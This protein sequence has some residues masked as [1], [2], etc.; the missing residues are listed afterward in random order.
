MSPRSRGLSYRGGV[1]DTSEQATSKIRFVASTCV[2]ASAKALLYTKVKRSTPSVASQPLCAPFSFAGE[3]ESALYR[4]CAP[5]SSLNSLESSIRTRMSFSMAQSLYQPRCARCSQTWQNMIAPRRRAS[6]SLQAG[7]DDRIDGLTTVYCDDFQCDSSPQVERAIRSFAKDIERS[8]VWTIS[9]FAEDVK[10]Q[11]RPYSTPASPIQ[12]MGASR[13]LYYREP[14]GCCSC[15]ASGRSL[16]L[17][18]YERFV[19]TA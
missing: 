10:Y 17:S 8:T 1:I 5:S 2:V 9:I 7:S 14:L 12:F 4:V 13:L 3:P 19:S 11:V 16:R 6:S 15:G 18:G